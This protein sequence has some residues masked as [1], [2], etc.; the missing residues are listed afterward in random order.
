MPRKTDYLIPEDSDEILSMPNIEKEVAKE[1]DRLTLELINEIKEV[2][3]V[4][5]SYNSIEFIEDE[6]KPVI[7]IKN[8]LSNLARIA[9]S[10]INIAINPVNPSK[11]SDDKLKYFNLFKVVDYDD[12]TGKAKIEMNIKVEDI[13]FPLRIDNIRKVIR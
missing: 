11:N 3:N 12:K 7:P 4:G 6:L 1:V 2:F 9:R 8:Y 10:K 5:I 13:G